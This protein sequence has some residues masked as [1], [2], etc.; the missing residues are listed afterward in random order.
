MSLLALLFLLPLQAAA[1]AK[2]VPIEIELKQ[3]SPEEVRTRDQL[4]RLLREHDAERWIFTRKIVIDGTPNL[5]PHS[6]PV[7]TLNTEYLKDDDLLLSTFVHEQLHWYLEENPESVKQAMEELRKLYPD[8]PSGPPWGARD[9]ESTYRHLIVCYWEVRAARELLGELRGFQVAQYLAH[10]HY[11]WVYRKVQEEG[12]KVGP[13][14]HK[15]GLIPDA[16]K[17][18]KPAAAADGSSTGSGAASDR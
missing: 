5:I 11:M 8:A 6:H 14:I 4:Q 9:L 15:H 7:L 13:L 2:P 12:Y 17:R 18:V 16:R 1:P 10:D 3:G